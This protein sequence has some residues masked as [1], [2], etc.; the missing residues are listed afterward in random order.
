V[1]PLNQFVDRARAGDLEA[2]GSVVRLTQQMAFAL[3]SNV[4]RDPAQAQDAVQEAYLTAFR[5]FADLDETAAFP[6]WFRRIV[7]TTALN[8]R[9][10]RRHAFLQLDDAPEPP[11]LDEGDP[12]PFTR[13]AAAVRS[14]LSRRLEHRAA[15][16]RRR[17]RRGGDAQAAAARPGQASQGDGDD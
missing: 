3:A 4:L 16:R 14:P 6:G 10:A 8:T 15:G 17:R 7:I 5:R 11:I 1:E 13:R 2:F 9:R 12:H